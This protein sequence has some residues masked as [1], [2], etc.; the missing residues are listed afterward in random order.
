MFIRKQFALFSAC[1]ECGLPQ[2]IC[3]QW[4][5]ASNDGR[6]FQKVKGAKC[7]YKGLLIRIF[8]AQRI[9]ALD[10]WAGNIARMMGLDEIDLQDWQQMVRLYKWLGELVEW[11]G[12]VGGG[13]QASR[14]CQVVTRLAH[15]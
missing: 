10:A 4:K 8:V 6:L 12:R 2:A 9:Q 13:I 11:G 15:R 14:I 1:F 5:A 3:K 7:Q